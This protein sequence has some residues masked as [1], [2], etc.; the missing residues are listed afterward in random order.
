MHCI[1]PIEISGGIPATRW[2]KS[3]HSAH[4]GNCVEVAPLPGSRVAVRDS[5]NP[6]SSPA[7]VSSQDWSVFIDKIKNGAAV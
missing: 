6:R 3:S 5:K 4:D 2:R 1:T 7:I